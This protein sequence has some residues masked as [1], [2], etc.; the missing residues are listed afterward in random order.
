MSFRHFIPI[1]ISIFLTGACYIYSNG[2]TL[3][4]TEIKID[5]LYKLYRE[6]QI[7][8]RLYLDKTE[9][10]ASKM[11]AE[12]KL[13]KTEELTKILQPFKEITW[14][15]PGLAEYKMKYY[16]LLIQNAQLGGRGGE[17]LYFLEKASRE[18]PGNLMGK[19][20]ELEIKLYF[21]ARNNNI[22]KVVE[23]YEEARPYLV[24]LPRLLDK[25]L[26]QKE[27][28]ESLYMLSLLIGPYT[29]TEDS[30]KITGIVR[31]AEDIYKELKPKTRHEPY[32]W[33]DAEFS[34]KSI[35]I[36]EASYFDDFEK[37][38]PLLDD[39][40]R[41]VDEN[42]N[43]HGNLCMNM[44]VTHAQWSLGYFTMLGQFDSVA[45]YIEKCKKL[46]SV[47]QDHPYMMALYEADLY[48]G[49]G[50]YAESYGHMSDAL[51]YGD[52]LNKNLTRETEKLRYLYVQSE[53]SKS[54]LKKVEREKRNRQLVIFIISLFGLIT[55]F[56]IYG[57]M[58]RQ[59][60][61]NRKQ[62]L[63]LRNRVNR[64]IANME[65]DR[66]RQVNEQRSRLK[67]ELDKTV[68]ENLTSIGEQLDAIK[69]K[70]HDDGFKN[71]IAQIKELLGNAYEAAGQADSANREEYVDE[72]NLSRQIHLLVENAFPEK[73]YQKNIQLDSRLLSHM[74]IYTQIEILR[75][76][77]EAVTNIL[78]HAKAKTVSVLFY[79]ESDKLILK[80]K[81]DGK[82]FDIETLKHPK[83]L[84]ISSMQERVWRLSGNLAYRSGPT[85]SEITVSLPALM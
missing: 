67:E 5:S 76:V 34:M 7:T 60:Q 29:Y 82:G 68:L 77:Q 19:F 53:K 36:I 32:D 73:K 83:G 18:S 30:A 52:D 62:I 79:R 2:Q 39:V 24:H 64:Q 33:L 58:L 74:D 72:N 31:L 75:I 20:T 45:Y 12:T 8:S 59:K 11:T 50:R 1:F 22:E 13:W 81:D 41:L 66:A 71:K 42:M 9:M 80:I 21:Y 69:T 49:Q 61:R 47:S 56:I 54:A 27:G 15:D 6:G 65:E 14:S 57:S 37:I 85:G 43:I 16:R 78:K 63:G 46:P 23:V 4:E 44:E 3:R 35:L 26:A 17:A 55:I 25:G 40:K 10:F 70:Y 51:R 48:A 84:G 28:A 38:K